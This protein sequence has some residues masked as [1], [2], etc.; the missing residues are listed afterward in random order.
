[1]EVLGERE[2]VK[3]EEKMAVPGRGVAGEEEEAGVPDPMMV[4][5]I[6]AVGDEDVVVEGVAGS[7][8]AV[9]VEEVEVEESS[10]ALVRLPSVK[11]RRLD[12]EGGSLEV[13]GDLA[14]VKAPLGPRG[15]GEGSGRVASGVPTG[16]KGHVGPGFGMGLSR[17]SG[18]G[19]PGSFP[20]QGFRPLGWGYLGPPFG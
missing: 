17:G 14:V 19:F 3:E 1:V 6:V 11:K 15:R 18:R 13:V 2:V 12:Q 8:V 16:S 20:R 10:V 9:S 4:S 7:V 5:H